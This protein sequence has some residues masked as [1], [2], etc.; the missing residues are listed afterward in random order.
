MKKNS[1]IRTLLCLCAALVCM[2][3]LSVSAFAAE[4]CFASDE[5]GNT[6]PPDAIETLTISQKDV[7]LKSDGSNATFEIDPNAVDMADAM[8]SILSLFGGNALTPDGNLTLVDDIQQTESV[9]S[10]GIVHSK[11]FVTLQSKNGNYFYLVIDRSGETENVYFLNLVDEAD[12]MALME[13]GEVTPKTCTCKDK[14]VA[15]HVDTTCPVCAA[16]MTECA[17]KEPVKEQTDTDTEGNKDE[18]QP[19]EKKS[20]NPALII[21]LVLALGGGAAYY[22]LK[23]KKNQPKTKG[24]TDLNEYDFGEDDTEMEFEPYEEIP[25]EIIG[26]APEANEGTDEE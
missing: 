15:G 10:N 8:K 19:E 9:D 25:A 7:S 23:V 3:S 12:L 18:Q 26:E 21:V 6:V 20:T 1:K 2:L 11:Q 24:N 4:D 13:G 14:C 16:N 5:T 22:F 17:G